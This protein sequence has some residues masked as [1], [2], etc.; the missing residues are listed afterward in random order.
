MSCNLTESQKKIEKHETYQ[1]QRR[2]LESVACLFRNEAVDIIK[3]ILKNVKLWG[4]FM[5]KIPIINSQ[6]QE[7]AIDKLG[8]GGWTCQHIREK[9]RER[10]SGFFRAR[11]GQV[12]CNGVQGETVEERQRLNYLRWR[13]GSKWVDQLGAAASK[14]VPKAGT[15]R[16]EDVGTKSGRL[17]VSVVGARREWWLFQGI[18]WPWNGS[19]RTALSVVVATSHT[20][21]RAFE[22]WLVHIQMCC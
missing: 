17:G 1:V 9:Q 16:K 10:L 15:S 7:R 22:V 2:S 20:Q 21:T 6:V 4:F 18:C 14:P 5:L 19:S 3:R 11:S 8:V 12:T 13:N